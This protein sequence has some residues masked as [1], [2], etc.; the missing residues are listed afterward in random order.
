MVRVNLLPWR[1]QKKI[2]EAKIVTR[3]L[4][5]AAILAISILLVVHYL[6]GN[7]LSVLAVDIVALTSE[8]K[9]LQQ[10]KVLSQPLGQDRNEY[11][12]VAK[13]LHELAGQ[14][15]PEICFS[16]MSRTKSKVLFIGRARSYVDFTEF[17]KNWRAAN[18]FS[19]IKIINLQKKQS[20]LQFRFQAQELI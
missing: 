1:A 10:T 11:S 5:T 8:H 19:D 12:S 20:F 16:E 9:K 17:I 13:L 18:L 6:L 4:S 3:M 15:N 2:Y 7:R 14:N